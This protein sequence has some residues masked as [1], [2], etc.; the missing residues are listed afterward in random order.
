MPPK[1]LGPELIEPDSQ[2]TEMAV[3]EDYFKATPR[4]FYE[5]FRT[6]P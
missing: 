4:L 5:Y 2:Y 1:E 3:Q 6:R